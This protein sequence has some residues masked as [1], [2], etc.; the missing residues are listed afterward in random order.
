MT[1]TQSSGK[2]QLE[3]PKRNHQ[4][5]GGT[6]G[7]GVEVIGRIDFEYLRNGQGV[8]LISEAGALEP[9][10]KTQAFQA[11]DSTRIKIAY[12]RLSPAAGRSWE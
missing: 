10:T 2:V 12:R 5:I 9:A 8:E 4:S 3:G 11:E 1:K 7:L 6:L